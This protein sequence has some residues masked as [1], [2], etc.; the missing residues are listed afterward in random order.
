MCGP[1]TD[2]RADAV[3]AALAAEQH[4]VVS[5]AQLLAAGISARQIDWR[6]KRHRL[7][8]IHRGV[9][10]VGHKALTQ[11]GIWLAAVL[12]GGGDTRLSFWSSASLLRLR[13]GSGPRSH[14]TCPRKRRSD[15]QIAFHQAVLLDDEVTEENGIPTTTPAR[16]TLDLAATASIPSL[17]RMAAAI[18][19]RPKREASLAELLDRYPRKPGAAKLRPIIASPIP[20]TRSD[21]EAAYL[22]LFQKAG[23]PP[24]RVNA[25]IEGHEVDFVWDAHGVA[26]ELDTYETHGSRVAFKSDRARDRKL[27]AR[28]IVVRL[29][30]EDPDDGIADLGRLLATSPHPT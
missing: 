22:E 8:V 16:T 28:W 11:E 25:V 4:G 15:G 13:K 12:A 23:I 27:A 1:A 30:D 18:G 14:V 17:T 10:A 2:H 29:T 7:H 9:Y 19:A 20:M 26:A 21:L 3:I 5:R 24:P 6:L